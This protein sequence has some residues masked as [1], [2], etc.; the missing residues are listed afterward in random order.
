M[1]KLFQAFCIL[2]IIGLIS[3]SYSIPRFALR[4]GGKC[5]DC[6]VNPSGGALRNTGGWKFGKNNLAMM[7]SNNENFKMSNMIGENISYGLDLR[8]QFLVR[9][10][11][12]TTQSDF[13][14]MAASV[15]TGLDLSEE[16]SLLVRYDFIQ[17]VYEGYAVARILPN[18]GY[19]KGGTFS[20]NFGIKMDDHT[21]YTRAGDFGL[22]FATGGRQGLIFTPDYVESG[23]EAGIFISEFA[24]LTASVGNPRRELF[25][26]DPS[27]TASLQ[28]TPS[29][30]EN[31]NLMLGGSFSN[32]K[33]K[34]FTTGGY[35]NVNMYAGF[36]GFGV[37]GIS[38]LGEYV[39]A[40]DYVVAE[41]V[42][43]ALMVEASYRIIK[44]LE[45]VARYDRFDPSDKLTKDE[46]SRIILGF[47]IFP[48]SFIEIRPQYR[49]QMENP[50][51]T[52]NSVVIQTHIY[53]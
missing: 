4:M 12:S 41:S 22:L 49:I 35:N 46:L 52:N 36:L 24:F 10:S 29:I 18:D 5:I 31:V 2:F 6:H 17:R 47:E 16:I 1:N 50:D 39:T 11:D 23:V 42:T 40:K 53:Y 30:G 44:G 15:Y 34:N 33:D 13:Q 3:E 45:F 32:F 7:S 26:T 51:V 37:S 43:T 8:G 9:T 21:A 19:I 28:L 27:Y 38:L 48:Y 25:A 20:P 14:R